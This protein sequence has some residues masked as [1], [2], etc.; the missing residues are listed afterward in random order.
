MREYEGPE[1]RTLS[2]KRR[3][4]R[5]PHTCSAC[6]KAIE[7]G[8]RY[9]AEAHLEDGK[10]IYEKVHDTMRRCSWDPHDA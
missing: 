5:K 10:F 9:Y 3:T 8:T 1:V 4:A 7:P 2:S 6:G